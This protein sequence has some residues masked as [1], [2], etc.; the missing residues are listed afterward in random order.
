MIK[1]KQVY[2]KYVN[3]FF[4]LFDCN[5]SI[6]YNTILNEKNLC[7]ANAFFRTLSQIDND[8]T[9]EIF[10]DNTNL[11]NIK[12]KDLNICYLPENPILFKRKSF[13]YN[14]SYPLKIR[15]INKKIIKNE[16]NS[17]IFKY[18]LN[19]LNKKIK[20]L[21]LSEQKIIAL[22]RAKIRKPKYILMDN[23]FNNFDE[24]YYDLAF[25]ILSDLMKSSIIIAHESNN[26][27]LKIFESFKHIEI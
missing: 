8:Y 6:E 13:E 21:N 22:L 12:S 1:F 17:L 5:C 16:I 26:L 24:K 9:G 23:F 11:K 3:D 20:K 4:S 7:G 14:L 2:V 10:V 19:N 27:N 25:E 18:N 15:K